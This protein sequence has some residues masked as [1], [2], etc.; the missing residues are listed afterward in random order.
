MSLLFN[1]LSMLVITFLPRSKCLL[2]S[3]LQSPSAVILEP[4]LKITFV[5]VSP[6]ICHE[7][8]GPDAMILVYSILRVFFFFFS[9]FFFFLPLIFISWRLIT[10][11]YCSGFCHTLNFKPSFSL[12]FHFHQEPLQFFFTFCQKGGVIWKSEVTD[13][14]LCNLDSSMCFIQPRISHDV[15]CI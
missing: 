2:I 5:I 11:Q 7:M 9:F 13:I 6:S 8:M 4:P 10:L 14:S 15:L 12:L 1:M 3:R